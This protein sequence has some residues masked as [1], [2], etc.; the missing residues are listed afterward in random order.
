MTS[1]GGRFE[2]LMMSLVVETIEIVAFV[3]AAAR[4]PLQMTL[5]GLMLSLGGVLQRGETS[6]YREVHTMHGENL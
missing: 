2:V 4:E 6:H 1:S 3:Q 5:S